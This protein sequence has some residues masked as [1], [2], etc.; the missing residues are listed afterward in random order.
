MAA[1][2]KTQ[3]NIMPENRTG[4]RHERKWKKKEEEKLNMKQ[5]AEDE[6]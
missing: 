1:E 6:P 5:T 4:T 3:D 2:E